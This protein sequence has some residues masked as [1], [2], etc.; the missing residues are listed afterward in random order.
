MPIWEATCVPPAFPIAEATRIQ[1][2]Y[3]AARFRR[4]LLGDSDYDSYLT[5]EFA[6][7]NEPDV[8]FFVGVL[9]IPALGALGVLG[10][11]T[12]LGLA[13]AWLA[14]RSLK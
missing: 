12:V 11:A 2:L 5:T 6:A 13:A 7:A 14:M 4:H 10:A 1:N 3:A 9:P 8:V